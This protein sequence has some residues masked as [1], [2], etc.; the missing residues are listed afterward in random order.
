MP[1]TDTVYN[2]NLL[3]R[4]KV[5]VLE[6]WICGGEHAGF[7]QAYDSLALVTIKAAGHEVPK[8]KPHAAYQM[9]YNFVNDKP[10][11]TAVQ[12]EVVEE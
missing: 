5:G 7:Y 8:F 9:F 2:L 10:I 12:M 4:K 6:P 1:Y 3:K 11:N